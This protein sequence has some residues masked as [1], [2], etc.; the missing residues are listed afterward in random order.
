MNYGT[1]IIQK[2][3]FGTR[4]SNFLLNYFTL[5]WLL[6]R[7]KRYKRYKR[8]RGVTGVTDVTREQRGKRKEIATSGCA[9]LAMTLL[10]LHNPWSEATK[11]PLYRKGDLGG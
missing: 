1:N 3:N 11:V 9:L 6:Q 7:Y 4:F 2:L 5:R 10:R 8:Y